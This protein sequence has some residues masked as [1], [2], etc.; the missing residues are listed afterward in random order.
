MLRSKIIGRPIF[1]L[2]LCGGKPEIFKVFRNSV[3][4]LACCESSNKESSDFN[5]L[6]F[7]GNKLVANSFILSTLFLY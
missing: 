5:S 4:Y 3:G 2:S 6:T 7:P 1:K